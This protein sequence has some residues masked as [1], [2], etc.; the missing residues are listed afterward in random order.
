MVLILM[1]LNHT[2]NQILSNKDKR[3]Q[4][5]QFGPAAFEDGG[6]PSHGVNVTLEELLQQFGFGGMRMSRCK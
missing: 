2:M 6:D 1:T 5:D 4:Y 3:A